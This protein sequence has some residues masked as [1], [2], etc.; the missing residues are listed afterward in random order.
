[1]QWQLKKQY[2]TK[3]K[4]VDYM[5]MVALKMTEREKLSTVRT[6]SPFQSESERFGKRNK[7]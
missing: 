4:F 1:M 3:I 2:T 6:S 5:F 7:L